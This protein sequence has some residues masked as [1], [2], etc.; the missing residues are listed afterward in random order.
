MAQTTTLYAA[1]MKEIYQPD[2]RSQVNDLNL[3]R[4]IRKQHK[5]E[6]KLEGKGFI[7]GLH[8]SRN[9]SGVMSTGESGLLGSAGQQGVDK[10]TIPFK[11]IKARFGITLEAMEA[12]ESNKAAITSALELERNRTVEDIERQMNRQFWG[13]G[14]G[15]LAVISSGT[16]SATQTLKDPGNVTGT[17]N[18]CRFIQPGMVLAFHTGATLDSVRTV[19]SVDNSADQ[20]V[21]TSSVTTDTNDNIYL[22]ATD[23]SN[24]NSSINKEMMGLSGIV[25]GTTYLSTVFGLD[26][27]TKTWFQSGVHTSVGTLS[28]DFLYRAIHNQWTKSGQ[29]ITDFFAGADVLR[30]Y[31]KLTTPDR[32]YMGQDLKKP[33]A[34][35]QNAGVEAELTFCGYPITVDKDAPYGHLFGVNL[36]S[37]YVAYLNEG[38]W[39][40]FGG[41]NGQIL[42]FVANKTDY[43][44]VY[45][46]FLN[47]YSDHGNH[48]FRC[49][50]ITSTQ[51]S[52][53]SA[54]AD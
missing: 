52:G 29:K 25:D 10:L 45:Y 30:E 43:E 6:L 15:I 4:K 22:G 21:L 28:E 39:E 50:G 32:R 8:S 48:H 16:A 1:V 40:D 44:G 31:I 2:I 53:N 18:P 9:Y 54:V 14:A 27:S 51:T 24:N 47:M 49:S 35:V 26:R 20:I 3:F 19:E 5:D 13:Y 36:N 37:V 38:Q 7:V 11:D 23:G 46:M 33:D 42:R 34:G 12:A 17:M 41:G